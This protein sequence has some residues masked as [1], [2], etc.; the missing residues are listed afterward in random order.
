MYAR[1]R[2]RVECVGLCLKNKKALHNSKGKKKKHINL[3]CYK[4]TCNAVVCFQ[5]FFN[6]VSGSDGSIYSGYS[7][8]IKL[9]FYDIILSLG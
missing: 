4:F 2:E 6:S 1:E 5:F 8:K 7:Q 3:F 9:H